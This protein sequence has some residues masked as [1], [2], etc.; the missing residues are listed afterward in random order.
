M[1]YTC[2]DRVMIRKTGKQSYSKPTVK[3]CPNSLSALITYENIPL[4]PVYLLI[5]IPPQNPS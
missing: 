4:T 1:S 3:D 5:Y 2:P